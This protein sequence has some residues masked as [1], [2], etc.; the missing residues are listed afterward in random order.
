[1]SAHNQR[2]TLLSVRWIW[3]W[4]FTEIIDMSVAFF[5]QKTFIYQKSD[6]QWKDISMPFQFCWL[7]CIFPLI[8]QERL[9]RVEKWRR[10]APPTHHFYRLLPF[11]CLARCVVQIFL[12]L[13]H[14]GQFSFKTYPCPAIL[15][16]VEKTTFPFAFLHP[17]KHTIV[18]KKQMTYARIILKPGLCGKCCYCPL[19]NP[20]RTHFSVLAENAT[21]LNLYFSIFKY[22]SFTL[23]K[24]C[25]FPTLKTYNS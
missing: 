7:G 12:L 3:R 17:S 11:T 19:R 13:H 1:M 2:K 18:L 23:S 25:N 15:A 14:L 10:W 4:A 20:G 6:Q 22:Q 16:P 5:T 9:H 8:I 24:H 21:A